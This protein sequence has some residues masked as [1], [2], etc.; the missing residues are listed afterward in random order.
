MFP[1]ATDAPQLPPS[2]AHH[3]ALVTS[4]E[5]VGET[6][7][8][9]VRLLTYD[10]VETQDAALSARVCVPIAGNSRGAFFI[11]DVGDEVVVCFLNGDPR[12]AV[13]LGSVW[14]GAAKPKESLGGDG[15]RV[16]RWTVVGRKGTRIA[17]VEEGEGAIIRLSTSDGSG[18]DIAFCEI[19]RDANGSI[20]LSAGGSKLRIEQSG[21]TLETTGT[22]DARASSTTLNSATV[23][24][25]AGQSSFSGQVTAAVVQTPSVIASSYTPGAGNVW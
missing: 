7:R 14:N 10:G 11:P 13:V 8:I 24:V 2:G 16:D 25:T 17:I 5:D 4:V 3:L 18:R 19:N 20:E 22:L 23:D 15:K 6:G 21:I 12:Q 9:S 1:R